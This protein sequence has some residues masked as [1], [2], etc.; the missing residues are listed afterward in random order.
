M[1]GRIFLTVLTVAFATLAILYQLYLGPVLQVGGRGRVV[2]AARAGR[3]QPH[4]QL[5]ACK[6]ASLH[7]RTRPCAEPY[8]RACIPR[9]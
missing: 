1:C 6:S 3:C 8:H 9:A 7:D 2:P 5:Q 4:K